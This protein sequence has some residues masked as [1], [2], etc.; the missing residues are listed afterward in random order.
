MYLNVNCTPDKTTVVFI[1]V[2]WISLTLLNWINAWRIKKIHQ[3]RS[4]LCNFVQCHIN[5][6]LIMTEI[7]DIITW[8]KK[9]IFI[10]DVNFHIAKPGQDVC[11]SMCISASP[12][13]AAYRNQYSPLKIISH[14]AVPP[15]NLDPQDLDSPKIPPSPLSYLYAESWLGPKILFLLTKFSSQNIWHI[16]VLEMPKSTH[17]WQKTPLLQ[18][19]TPLQG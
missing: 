13:L 15:R 16:L 2:S 18:S 7:C 8:F 5:K 10:A 19:Y 4:P 1:S 3:N 14:S 6:T 12:C 9:I 11:M 17:C